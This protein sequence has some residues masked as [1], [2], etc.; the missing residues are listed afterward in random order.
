MF[1]VKIASRFLT[2]HKTQSLVIMLGI[3]VG[4]SVQ[5]FVGLLIGSL[6]TNLIHQTV[7]RSPH[8]TILPETSGGL[9]ADSTAIVDQLKE[10][11]DVV[12]PAA[13]ADG[14]A[15]IKHTDRDLPALV[16]GFTFTDADGMYHFQD[17]LTTGTLPIEANEV[18]IGKS[19]ATELSV[20]AG[21]NVTLITPAGKQ[22]QVTITGIFDQ[23]V[24]AINNLWVLAPL[25]S[26]QTLFDFGD[27]V[28]SIGMQV[29]DVFKADTVAT[30][31]TGLLDTQSVKVTSWKVQNAQLLSALQGQSSSSSM[32]QV[33]IILSVVI[34]IASILAITVMQKSRQVG[35]LKAMGITD[36][37]ASWIFIIQGALLGLGGAILGVSLGIGLF[38]SFATFVKTSDGAAVVPAVVDVK[39]ALT[40][41]AIALVAAT[42]AGLFPART[43]ARLSPIEVIRNG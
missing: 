10:Q 25:A 11:K 12:Y 37:T 9:I 27:R 41:G 39:F 7:G 3:A 38:L 24:E 36:G 31:V 8:I 22:E 33:F 14:N 20:T 4:V 13:V 17:S 18:A 29:T 40:S 43:S 26:V 19:M 5:V 30:T 2:S 42:L 6:Q 35:I 32:I 15:F 21:D 23:K 16:R 28:T 1:A 34:A